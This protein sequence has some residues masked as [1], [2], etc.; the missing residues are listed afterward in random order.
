V[1][2][3]V[4]PLGSAETVAPSQPPTH[5]ELRVDEFWRAEIVAGTPAVALSDDDDS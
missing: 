1:I 5:C 2:R 3:V 4:Q